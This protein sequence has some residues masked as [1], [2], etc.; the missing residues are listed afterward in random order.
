MVA[1]PARTI[2]VRGSCAATPEGST[3]TVSTRI[4]PS[5]FVGEGVE[6]GAGVS[7]GPNAVLLGPSSIGDGV[8]IGPGATL[9]APPEISS[10]R[11][12]AAWAGD[13]DHAGVIIGARTVIR[14]HVVVHQGSHRPTEVGT[15]CWLLNRSYLAHD[16]MTGDG[17]TISAGVSIGGH[18]VIGNGVNLGMNASVHQRRVV[19]AGAMV[20][21]GTPLTRDVPPFGKV[22][23]SPSRLQGVNTVG[24]SRQGIG[25]AEIALVVRAYEAGDTMLESVEGATPLLAG[26][27]LAWQAAE[28]QK[29]FFRIG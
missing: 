3:M 24:M 1:H 23:G 29:P 15:D 26:A 28:P 20:G 6:L 2:A 10:L 22:F 4:H 8:W 5:A 9:G 11:Q 17:V 19:G 13:L 14:E 7:I 16:V 12:N 25:D 21:M 27:I 18:C